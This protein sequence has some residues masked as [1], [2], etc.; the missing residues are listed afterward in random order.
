MISEPKATDK[1]QLPE[2]ELKAKENETMETPTETPNEDKKEDKKSEGAK[3]LGE[4][5]VKELQAMATGEGIFQAEAFNTKAQLIALISNVRSMKAVSKANVVTMFNPAQAKVGSYDA[6]KVEQSWEEKRDRTRKTLLKG[7]KT[8]MM[9][10]L[11]IGEK[12]GAYMPVIVNGWRLDY[13]KGVMH[14]DV[15][16]AISEIIKNSL[17]MTMEAGSEHLIDNLGS[18]IDEKTGQHKDPARLGV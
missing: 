16:E 15:P 7:K 6:K 14:S 12:R 8:M 5:T 18:K 4:Y 13:M 2:E 3:P 17:N 11:D 10:P 1:K 9:I